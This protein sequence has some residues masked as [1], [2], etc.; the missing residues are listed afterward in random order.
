MAG[1]LALR[2]HSGRTYGAALR[3]WPSSEATF[4]DAL[5]PSVS[6]ALVLSALN[7]S[8]VSA[9]LL[10]TD[11][12]PEALPMGPG[13]RAPP[14]GAFSYAAEAV[15]VYAA[16]AT[17]LGSLT[18]AGVTVSVQG[19]AVPGLGGA[20]GLLPP[21]VVCSNV[22]SL[23]RGPDCG[24]DS[25]P[26]PAPGAATEE[27]VLLFDFERRK[28]RRL[29][30]RGQQ[31]AAAT[32]DQSPQQPTVSGLADSS[33]EAF[34]AV[35]SMPL[36]GGATD[37]VGSQAGAQSWFGAGHAPGTDVTSC[38]EFSFQVALLASATLVATPPQSPTGSWVLAADSCGQ[39][40]TLLQA[41]VTEEAFRTAGGSGLGQEPP[42]WC[43]INLS[44]RG[45]KPNHF[46]HY[47]FATQVRDL[48]VV[49]HPR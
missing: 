5:P 38:T 18:T 13:G 47:S 3:A 44:W 9:P 29:A 46:T 7:T 28:R 20:S 11:S 16:W 37:T 40:S 26:A 30:L 1:V 21:L 14:T 32:S 24:P 4:E 19:N 41:L 12:F 6:W 49:F 36:A 22:Q 42:A 2:Q 48:A 25:P 15:P 8:T 23:R 34:G 17:S 31:A 27:N 43:G 33:A 10:P 45:L 35:G 39:S